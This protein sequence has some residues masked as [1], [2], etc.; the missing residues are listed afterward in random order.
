MP[1]AAGFSYKTYRDGDR[2]PLLVNKVYS[3]RTQL[4]YA[5]TE[6]P[7]ACP[8]TGRIRTGH[9]TSGT[10]ISLNLGEVLRGDRITISDYELVMGTDEEARYLCSHTMDLDGLSRTK[11]LIRHGYVAEWI[12]DNLPGAM[13][14]Q[15]TD[16]MSKYYVAGFKIG[17]EVA[18][19]RGEQ[20]QYILNNHVTL[21][22]R[23]HRAPGKS[24][25]QGN[26]VIVGFE[27]FPRSIT[28]SG[29]DESG[30]PTG[31]LD[32]QKPFLLVPRSNSTSGDDEAEATS[33]TVPFTYSVYWREEEKLEWRNRWDMYFA[34]QDD[35]S[36][37]HW[38][39]IVS[40]LVICGL[41]TTAVTLVLVRT[42]RGDKTGAQDGS[43]AASKLRLKHTATS[44]SPIR[45]KGG[46]LDSLSDVE[47]DAILSD[48]EDIEEI[49]GWKL[50]HGDVF[51]APPY[52]GLLAPLVGSGI[53]LLF[54]TI[55]LLILSAVGVL[56]PSFRG[57]YISVGVGLFVFAGLFSGYYSSRIY[58]TFGGQLWQKNVLVT[59]SLV[60][61]LLFATIF[62]L[63]LFVWIQASSTAIPFGT[64]IALISLWLFIQL[65]LVY[66]GGWFGFER[67]GAWSHPIKANAIPRQLPQQRWCLR[68]AQ[69]IL[70]AG[71]VPF[72][73][74]YIE[75]TF[76]CKSLW[77]DKSTYYYAF[78]YTSI[79]GGILAITVVEVTIVVTHLLLC[80]EV[81]IPHTTSQPHTNTP[82]RTTT[83]GGTRS[84]P[85]APR[86]SGSSPTSS[87]TTPPPCTSRA[88]CR[89]CCFS[90]MVH[91]YVWFMRS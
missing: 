33:L 85:A 30:I 21:V 32:E 64:L 76:A 11:E 78:G 61:G 71:L 84:S 29:R 59:A 63:N 86:R 52:G 81:C 16:K 55:G 27:V 75:L 45:E 74:I 20:P 4:Q 68:S 28:A 5:Y 7:F 47:A 13:S 56:N 18:S 39:A 51:R 58:R 69:N 9:F 66:I 23:Y 54:M 46:L 65:P 41:L 26:K 25:E 91:F 17:E 49:S 8:P 82:F 73:V 14:F 60:P 50:I 40:S 83:G 70:L 67:I 24:G 57:G 48:E 15:T 38:L 34:A 1:I 6:L 79:V 31:I 88:L 44:K 43:L 35:S 80:A 3:D 72:T 22:V 42:V 87:T 62:I 90:R 53:Q 10:S 36:D 77:M 12:V 19:V 89:V 2:I 37:V